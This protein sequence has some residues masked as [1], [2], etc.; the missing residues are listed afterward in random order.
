[1]AY[2]LGF[3]ALTYGNISNTMDTTKQAKKGKH[4]N[5]FRKYHKNRVSKYNLQIYD[6][7]IGGDGSSY[8]SQMAAPIHHH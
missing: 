8:Y 3:Y 2:V 4:L 5:N 7:N 6:T 1:M